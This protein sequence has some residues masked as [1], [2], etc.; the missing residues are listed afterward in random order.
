[1]KFLIVVLLMFGSSF[2]F[3]ETIQLPDAVVNQQVLGGD[4]LLIKM[5]DYVIISGKESQTLEKELGAE[6]KKELTRDIIMTKSVEELIASYNPSNDKPMVQ[7]I[8]N[9]YA[10]VLAKIDSKLT[11]N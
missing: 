1:M 4:I 8:L 2:G 9:R 5:K 7:A 3:A 6:T 11:L 10:A